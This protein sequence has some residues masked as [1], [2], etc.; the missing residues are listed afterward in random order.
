MVDW[1]PKKQSMVETSVFGGKYCVMKHGIEN[2]CGIC[3]KLCMMG[4]PIKG[5]SYINGDNMRVLINVSKP[6]SILKK[7]SNSIC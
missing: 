2:L 1:L 7:K 3:F 5:A 6:E 4:I